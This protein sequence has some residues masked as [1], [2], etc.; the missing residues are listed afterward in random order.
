[1]QN[2]RRKIMKANKFGKLL[3]MILCLGLFL[4]SAS[5]VWANQWSIVSPNEVIEAVVHL[6]EETGSIDYRVNLLLPEKQAALESSQLGLIVEGKNFSSHFTFLSKS[7]LMTRTEKYTLTS[8]KQLKVEDTYKQC[9]LVFESQDG[10]KL[11]L[12]F[13]VFDD[14]VAY[15]FG[16]DSLDAKTSCLIFNDQ[17]TFNLPEQGKM[18]GQPYDQVSRWT[19]AYEE[20]Y[21]DGVPVGTRAPEDKNGWAFPLLFQTGDVWTLIT[22]AAVFN[23]NAA[24]HLE[25]DCPNG[26]YQICLPEE[27]E[28]YHVCSAI[29]QVNLPWISPWRVVMVGHSLNTIF[30]STIVTSLCPS[31]LFVDTDWIKPGRS[32]WSWWS[33]SNSPKDYAALKNFVDL[34]A[35]MGWEYSLVDANWN[36]MEGGDLE[37]L[38]YYAQT[39][40][41]ALLVWFNSGGPHNTVGEEVRD[42]M[43]ESEP[44][45]KTFAWLQEIGVKGVKVDFFQSDKSCI[46]QQYHD[47]L[48]DAAEFGLVVNFHGCTLPRGWRRTYPNLVSM[49]SVRGGE[50]YKF[51]Q[52]FSAAAPRLNA[53]YP[54]NRNVVGPMDYTP[55]TF[56]H[57]TYQH[58][59]S[60]GH[61][62]AL[63][64][65]FESGILHLA[66]GVESYRS[67]P[68]DV[69]QYLKE[70][71]VVWD[72]SILLSGHPGKDALIARRSGK[73]WYVAGINGEF[74]TSAFEFTP[75]FLQEGIYQM[76]LIKD[77][78]T[79]STFDIVN[80][81]VNI[82]RTVD[83]NV[84]PYGGFVAVFTPIE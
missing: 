22:E 83:V 4:L 10:Y 49:E 46:I 74:V 8:G 54:F 19:P 72:E 84:L 68:E 36:H 44:R 73:N 71:P 13:K 45:R 39:K 7:K 40:N 2:D 27:D 79:V 66:D 55:V 33:A 69:I 80:D 16:I 76:K 32:S 15:Q 70:V 14:G 24:M 6:N 38:A 51:D 34:S 62:L 78:A 35:E 63:T 81:S 28:A 75:S 29:P 9:N 31:N 77:G 67:L 82:S 60:F 41:V 20:Y 58:F 50:C 56:S 47:I 53:S 57:N 11:N 17:S 52:Q 48:T 5:Y 61:E 59:T 23:R 64:V 21:V 26:V 42:L 25:A 1:M 43:H 18:W 65:I 12:F 30:Q 3:G 37:K